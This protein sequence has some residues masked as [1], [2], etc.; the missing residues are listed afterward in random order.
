MP[1]GRCKRVG[2]KGK[3]LTINISLCQCLIFLHIMPWKKLKNN[4]LK[5]QGITA[6]TIYPTK[7]RQNVGETDPE[8]QKPHNYIACW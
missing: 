5:I 1:S 2:H 8:G 6:T 7:T 3:H 4:Y